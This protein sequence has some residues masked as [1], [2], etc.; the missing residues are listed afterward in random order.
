MTCLPETL[1][2]SGLPASIRRENASNDAIREKRVHPAV[3]GTRASGRFRPPVETLFITI[4]SPALTA[5]RV[6]SFERNA[7]PEING[8]SY[9]KTEGLTSVDW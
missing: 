8:V 2:I 9:V 7:E 5:M 6:N 3:I 1:L 4:L